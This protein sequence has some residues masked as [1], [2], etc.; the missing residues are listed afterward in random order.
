[1]TVLE[2]HQRLFQQSVNLEHL[3]KGKSYIETRKLIEAAIE[4]GEMDQS[5]LKT[6]NTFGNLKKSPDNASGNGQG[7]GGRRGGSPGGSPGVLHLS[8]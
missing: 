7:G 3:K 2:Q 1:M 8:D 6:Y 4:K 5:V